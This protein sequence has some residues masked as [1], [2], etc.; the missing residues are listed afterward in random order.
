MKYKRR[1]GKKTINSN[2]IKCDG[3]N[4]SSGLERYTYLALKKAK[5]Y[6][7]DCYEGETFEVLEGFQFPNEEYARQSN[8]KGEYIL[9]SPKKVLGIKYTPDFVTDNWIIECKGR[10]NESFPIRW[11]LFK[12]YLWKTGDNRMLFKPQ[13]QKEVDRTIEIIKNAQD[14]G[15]IKKRQVSQKDSIDDQSQAIYDQLAFLAKEK[16]TDLESLKEDL[17]ELIYTISQRNTTSE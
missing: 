14:A 10:A 8:G 9:R 4:F 15:R 17:S 2:K 16:S 6:E 11:K 12:N 7:P 13:N 5:L 3:I 1:K